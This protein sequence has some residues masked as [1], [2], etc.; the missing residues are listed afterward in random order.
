MKVLIIGGGGR[1][2]ALAWKFAQSDRV[3]DVYVA[4]GN[5]GTATMNKGTNVNIAADDI[6]GLKAFAKK[7]ENI[8]LTVV[9]PEVALVAGVVNAFREEGLKVFGPDANGARLEGSKSFSKRFMEKYGIPTANFKVFTDF[10]EAKKKNVGVFGYP[11][12]IKADGLAAGK[13]VVIAK[14]T[15]EEAL[16]AMEDMMVKKKVFGEAGETVLV[17]EFLGGLEA[18]VLCFVDGKTI[19]PMESVQDYKRIFDNNQGPNTGGMGTYSPNLIYTDSIEEKVREMVLE[20][21]RKGLEAEKMD[22]KGVIFIG[23]MI[24]GKDIRVLE[25]NVRFGDPETQVVM[26][27]LQN[28]IVDVTEAILD[29]RLS[30]VKL[31]WDPNTYICVILASEGY[32]ENYQKGVQINGLNDC[33]LV[34]HSGTKF[35]DDVLKTNGGRVLGVIGNG[36]NIKEARKSVYGQLEKVN[37]NGMQYR[38]DI[39]MLIRV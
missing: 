32:P 35:E 1:E 26:P 15:E 24:D 30:Q 29:Q 5:G 14:K 18:S 10:E 33:D 28:D 13:G 38:T 11:M 9:G 17:E 16:E 21:V 3:K 19:V 25:F 22:Y 23:L 37:F 12:V 4:P 31:E 6:E 8:D 34:F 27:K 2:H 20:P 39:G 7:N 36:S